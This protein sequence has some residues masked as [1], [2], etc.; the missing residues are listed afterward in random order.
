MKRS[1]SDATTDTARA[2]EMRRNFDFFGAPHALLLSV[3][4]ELG[5]YGLLDCGLFV[6]SFLRAVQAAGLGAIAQGSIALFSGTL[7]TML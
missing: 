6:E 7:R 5:A 1:V 2:A 3:H 4:E